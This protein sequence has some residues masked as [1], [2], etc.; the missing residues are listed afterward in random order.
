MEI[1]NEIRVSASPNN[2][3]IQAIQITECPLL[4]IAGPGLGKTFTL[5]KGAFYLIALK[6][7]SQRILE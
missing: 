1:E 4:I 2:S 5:V 6:T 7:I 3:Q